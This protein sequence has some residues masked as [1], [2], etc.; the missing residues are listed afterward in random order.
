MRRVII[1]GSRSVS[2]TVEEIDEAIA[3][4]PAGSLLWVPSE[5]TEIIC[6]DARGADKAGAAWAAARGIAVH[7]EPITNELIVRWGKYLAPKMRNRAMAER[8]DAAI[9][10]WDGTSGGSADMVTRM[11]VRDKPVAVVPFKSRKR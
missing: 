4:L 6:G 9:V 1:A 2:P 11:V 8:A 3:R 10:F 5:W 7:H